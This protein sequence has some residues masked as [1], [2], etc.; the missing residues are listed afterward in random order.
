MPLDNAYTDLELGIHCDFCKRSAL[1]FDMKGVLTAAELPLTFFTG[2]F[3][4]N[5]KFA[6]PI[7]FYDIK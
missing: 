2:L 6:K 5:I 1:H 7:V 3:G 4:M